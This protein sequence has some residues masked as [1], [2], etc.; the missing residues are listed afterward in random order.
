MSSLQKR[1]LSALLMLAIFIGALLFS[2]TVFVLLILIVS[3]IAAKEWLFLVMPHLRERKGITI[4][5]MILLAVLAVLIPFFYSVEFQMLLYR[6]FT[7]IFPID[8]IDLPIRILIPAFL[9]VAIWLLDKAIISPE[10]NKETCRSRQFMSIG[11]VYI[12]LSTTAILWIYA[13][14]RL[15]GDGSDGVYLI[16]LLCSMVWATDIFAYFSGKTIGGA[17]MAPK[18]SPNKTWAGLIGGM[19]GS[20]IVAMIFG[21]PKF[22]IGLF[23]TT[24]LYYMGLMGAVLAVI[25]QVGDLIV[26]ALKRKYNLKDTGNIIP[27]HG[28]VLDRIDG[29][30]LVSLA[31][32]LIITILEV[33]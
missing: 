18:I 13:H 2:P 21:L 9:A 25:G 30:L 12:M 11:L 1:S 29:L 8:P 6:K 3:A 19:A 14:G 32:A 4:F 17:K 22:S 28:G 20:A 7:I 5:L 24:P 31:F 23:S 16:L 33:I 10:C 15:Y 26:S 27:G